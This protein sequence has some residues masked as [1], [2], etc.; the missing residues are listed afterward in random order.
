MNF[1]AFVSIQLRDI[2][3]TVFFKVRFHL[4]A[5]GDHEHSSSGCGHAKR[6]CLKTDTTRFQKGSVAFVHPCCIKGA[7]ECCAHPQR[8]EGTGERRRERWVWQCQKNGSKTKM[9]QAE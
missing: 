4:D 1:L 8:S 9:N 7:C 3:G 6:R 2:L 5:F